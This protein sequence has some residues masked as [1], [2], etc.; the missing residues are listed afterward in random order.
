MPLRF[1]AKTLDGNS[2]SVTLEDLGTQL[3]LDANKRAYEAF[4]TRIT[5][6]NGASVDSAVDKALIENTLIPVDRA[7]LRIAEDMACLEH[8]GI[9][10]SS[11][12]EI[13]A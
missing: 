2:T 13:A 11:L 12:V 4:V 9:D 8:L 6:E 1:S 5:C 7:N 10:P 3:R